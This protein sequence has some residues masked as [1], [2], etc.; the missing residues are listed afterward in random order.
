[1][2]APT[3][4]ISL[5]KGIKDTKGSEV[6]L[7]NF[8]HDIKEGVWQ[9]LVLPIRA[10][11]TKD[12]RKEL[13]KRLPN[14]T[15]SGVFTERLDGSIKQH[16]NYIAIDIDDLHKD[17]NAVKSILSKDP[18]VYACFVSVSGTGLCAIF[19]IDGSRHRDAFEGIADYLYKSYQLIVDRSGINES[20]ARFASFDPH[21]Y[22]NENATRFKKYL[23]KEKPKKIAQYVYVE[24][25]FDAIIN[26]LSEKNIC[27]DYRDWITVGYSIASKFGDAGRNYYHILSQSATKYD[28]ADCD[29]QYDNL[30]KTL[31]PTKQRQATINTIYHYAKMHGIQTYSERTKK[32]LQSTTILKKSGLDQTG[33]I[34]NLQKFEGITAGESQDIVKQAFEQN[35]EHTGEDSIITQIENWLKYNHDLKRNAITRRIENHGIQ[36]KETDINT[37]FLTAKKMF[38]DITYDIFV[39]ILYSDATPE[40][41]PLKDFFIRYDRKPTG[42][43]DELFNTVK[44]KPNTPSLHY[45]GTKWL[46]GIISAIHGTHSPLML[47]LTGGQNTGKTEWFRRLLPDELRH[48]Y[49]ES[50]LDAGK[51]DDILMTQKVVIMDDEMG[52]KSK[53]ESKR[54]KELLSKQTFSLRV[55]YGKGNEDL[56]R[57]AVLCGTSNDKQILNDPTGNRRIIP[58]EVLSIDHDAF[59]K[60]DKIDIFIEAYNLYKSGYKWQLN[61]M[62]IEL[63]NESSYDFVDYSL[64]YEMLQK[65]LYIPTDNSYNEWTASEVKEYIERS[66]GQRISLKKL[67]Q[68]LK[69]IG[70]ECEIKKRNNKTVQVYKICTYIG[71]NETENKPFG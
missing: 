28:S 31:S 44:T 25:D 18:Y 62:D 61:K 35:I 59:N 14:V 40:Y 7:N 46:V 55:P 52:G 26:A 19:H 30:L 12:E 4:R 60:I 32:I 23:P 22:F 64:E 57:L 3:I 8:L 29:K 5:Y 37:L 41:N 54:L 33:V 45:Y 68:E 15:I 48:Y 43:I 69:S 16:S 13:K 36:L 6:D 56:S 10:L 71:I 21:M 9:D 1:M 65:Y 20:R 27:E 49:A 70:F 47:V 2:A 50:K 17:I 39:K 67:G 58:I 24:T 11:K 42:I 66:S 38:E 63:M 34:S 53:Q 51:D